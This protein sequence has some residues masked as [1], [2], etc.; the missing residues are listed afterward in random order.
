MKM[1][2]AVALRA[3]SIFSILMVLSAVTAWVSQGPM[4]EAL[5]LI[6]GS[7]T[8]LMRLLAWTAP[9]PAMGPVRVRSRRR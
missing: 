7:L 9:A 6:G 4:A 1:N 5:C 2:R 3:C 8:A